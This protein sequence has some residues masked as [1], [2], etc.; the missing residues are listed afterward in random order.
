[1]QESVLASVVQPGT[2]IGGE[3]RLHVVDAGSRYLPILKFVFLEEMLMDIEHLNQPV[4]APVLVV[5]AVVRK[6]V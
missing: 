6:E 5:L 4:V 2:K 1:M 3:G